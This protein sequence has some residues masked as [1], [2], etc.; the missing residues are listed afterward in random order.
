[1]EQKKAVFLR[2][3]ITETPPTVAELQAMLDFMQGNL[4]K[5]FNSSGQLYRELHLTEKLKSM[6]QTDAL[7]LLSQNGMLVKRPF[8]LGNDFGLI[9]FSEAEWVKK[10]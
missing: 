2:K 8:L 9:G 7:T 5:L 4:K 1:M 10:F 3:E 6:T